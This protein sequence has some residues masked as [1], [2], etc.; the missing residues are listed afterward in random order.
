MPTRALTCLLALVL[1]VVAPD[2]PAQTNNATDQQAK[3]VILM[4]PDGMGLATVT[5]TRLRLNGADGAPLYLETLERIGYQRTFAKTNTIPDSSAAASAMACGEKFVNNEVC[6]HADR[7]P[8]NRS[9]LEIAQSL[10][11]STGLVATQTITHATPAA[12]ASHLSN[13]NCETEIARQYVQE[14]RPNVLHG[15]GRATFNPA[16]PDVCGVAGDHIAMAAEMGYTYVDT[17]SALDKA[18]DSTPTRLLGL[19]AA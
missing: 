11:M 10:G 14:V 3:Y 6:L 2:L 16:A 5:A 7:A 1:L 9:V 4:I 15:G 18:L 19:F 13:R 12:F 17:K 8:H